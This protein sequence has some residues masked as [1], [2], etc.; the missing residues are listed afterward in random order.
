M[1]TWRCPCLLFVLNWIFASAAVADSL[2]DGP[3]VFHDGERT[4]AVWICDAKVRRENAGADGRIEPAC[5]SVPELILDRQATVGADALPQSPR[6]AAVSDIHGQAGVF[7][8]LLQAQHIT[9]KDDRWVWG[10]SVLVI[11]GDVLDRGPN[12]VESL[13]AI[14]RLAQEASQAG[15]HVELVLGNHEIM[16]LRGDLRYLNPKYDAVARLLGQRYDQLYGTH[17]ELGAWLRRRAT[18]LKVGD[19]LFTHGGLH[20]ELATR[21]ID[22]GAINAAIRDGIE[23]KPEALARRPDIAWLLGSAGPTWYRGYFEAPRATSVQ[24]DALLAGTGVKRMVVG[25]TTQNEIQSLYQGRVIAVDAG[26]KMGVRGEI[27]IWDQQQL[28]RGLSDGRRLPLMLGDND[29]SGP[30]APN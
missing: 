5:G 6:W 23:S 16:V 13:W 24:V 2:N 1:C 7:L 3:Y 15:G 10:S 28:W 22:L 25:H 27:L 11:V 14:Y 4:E 18:V 30:V 17:S 21:S 8:G 12:Q 20:P 19:T 26:I 9:D 29:G